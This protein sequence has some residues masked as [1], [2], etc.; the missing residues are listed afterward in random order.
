MMFIPK[1][2]IHRY[3][4]LDAGRLTSLFRSDGIFFA[5]GDDFSDITKLAA[6]VENNLRT[7][8]V[9]MLGGDPR[10]EA[11]IF[12]PMHT[13]SCYAAHFVIKDGHR[14]KDA[15]GRLVESAKYVF[16]NTPCMAIMGFIRESNKPA[17]RLA[18]YVGMG[19]VG[20]TRGTLMFGG[21]MVDEVIYQCTPE[22]F[23][24]KYGKS[25]G[26]IGG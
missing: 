20:V 6:F 9:Y 21:R 3:S 10:H 5:A 8:H 17:C 1:P 24:K 11:F 7:P 14:G 4:I 23:N 19:R 22:D 12:L 25:L 13:T 18:G 26:V 16:E 2:S 15:I